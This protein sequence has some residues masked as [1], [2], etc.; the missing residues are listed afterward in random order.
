MDYV[1]RTRL[2]RDV[3]SGRSVR[4]SRLSKEKYLPEC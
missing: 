2:G 4:S 1:A 3:D